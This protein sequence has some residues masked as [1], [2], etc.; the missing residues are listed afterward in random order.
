MRLGRAGGLAERIALAGRA[1]L[2]LPLAF[3]RAGAGLAFPGRGA[4]AAGA[5]SVGSATGSSGASPS[6][7]SA[8]TMIEWGRPSGP[9]SWPRIAS[10]RVPPVRLSAIFWSCALSFSL[11]SLPPFSR[12]QASTTSSM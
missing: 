11:P 5:T 1:G 8:V 3:P 7:P 6:G 4:S 2:V 9:P 12:P 10:V